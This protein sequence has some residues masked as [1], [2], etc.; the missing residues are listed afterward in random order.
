LSKARAATSTGG[1]SPS[2]SRTVIAG[3]L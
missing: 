1:P 2:S 3:S